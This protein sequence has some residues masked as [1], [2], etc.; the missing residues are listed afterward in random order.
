MLS[1]SPAK[2]LVILVIALVVLGPEKLPQVARQL[3]AAWHDLRQWRSRMENEVR[4]AFPNLPPAHEVAQVVRS[5]LAFLDRLADEHERAMSEEETDVDDPPIP[6]DGEAIGPAPPGVAVP[7][8]ASETGMAPAAGNGS[9]AL[10]GSVGANG[11]GVGVS[12][13]GTTAAGRDGDALAPRG[14]PALPD[15]PSMN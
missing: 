14:F 2:L 11:S 9:A 15:D 6:L 10:N 3:G 13:P 12:S 8:P 7:E 5:P 1:L 4:G